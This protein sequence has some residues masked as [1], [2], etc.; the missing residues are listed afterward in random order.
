[1]HAAAVREFR[2]RRRGSQRQFVDELRRAK[3]WWA[4]TKTDCF[5][6]RKQIESENE[7]FTDKTDAKISKNKNKQRHRSSVICRIEALGLRV[8]KKISILQKGRK[9]PMLVK[10][11]ESKIALGRNLASKILIQ[12]P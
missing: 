10:V 6:K 3:G 12:L 7:P 9:G 11:G 8:G 4:R 5:G 1:M 2:R